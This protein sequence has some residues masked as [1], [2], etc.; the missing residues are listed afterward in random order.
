MRRFYLATGY[1]ILLLSF[2][3]SNLRFGQN[4]SFGCHLVRQCLKTILEEARSWRS[5]I[6]RTPL[7]DTNAPR[8]R[9]SLRVWVWPCAGWCKQSLSKWVTLTKSSSL[10]SLDLVMCQIRF[11]LLQIMPYIHD[12]IKCFDL[13]LLVAN[14]FWVGSTYLESPN[15]VHS[16]L[17]R[18]KWGRAAAVIVWERPLAKNNYL[19][20]CCIEV[21]QIL[22]VVLG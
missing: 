22:L 7:G 2:H 13:D 8:L 11:K 18:E 16:A 21:T 10:R 5:Q 1:V 19:S 6:L 20:I 12:V 14:T 15:G 17:L 9:S 4:Q 3:R